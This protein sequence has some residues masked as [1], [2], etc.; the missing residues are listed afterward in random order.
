[1][2]TS[3][4]KNYKKCSNSEN[5]SFDNEIAIINESIENMNLEIDNEK[6]KAISSLVQSIP[7][8]IPHSESKR[9]DYM[10]ESQNWVCYVLDTQ[11]DTFSA[12]LIDK[13]NPTTYEVADFEI[14]EVPEGDRNL[15]KKGAI[16]YWSIGY[17]N[18]ISGIVKQSIIKFRRS[19]EWSNKDMEE[20]LSKADHLSESIS[21]T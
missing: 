9:F 2:V 21:W 18:N 14:K 13:N 12:K 5:N 11:K 16:F 15:I 10:Y 6:D 17:A 4:I 20:I 3:Q 7:F 8:I 1:M 19:I